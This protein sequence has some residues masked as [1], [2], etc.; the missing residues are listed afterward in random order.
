MSHATVADLGGT[1]KTEV[2]APKFRW[3]LRIVLPAFLILSLAGVF[4]G[5]LLGSLTPA[6]EVEV[7]PVVQRPSKAA[8]ATANPRA[9]GPVVVQAAGWIEPDPFPFNVTA[10]VSGTVREVLVLEGESVRAG[11]ILVRLVD[12]DAVLKHR[13]AEAELAAAQTSWDTN[14]EAQ[15]EYEVALA[16]EAE[17]SAT[18]GL[19]RAELAAAEA[20]LVEAKLNFQ[21][22]DALQDS[23]SSS[24]ANYTAAEAELGVRT[25]GVVGAGHRIAALAAQLERASAERHAAHQ[26]LQLRT[27]ERLRLELAR[28]MADEAKLAVDRLEIRSPI[29]GVVMTRLVE[30]GSRLM[31]ESNSMGGAMVAQLYDPKQMQVRVDVPLADAAKVG[32]GQ[33][34]EV[35]VEILSDRVFRGTVSR[36]TNFADIQ[37]NTLQVKVALE[38]PAPELKPEMLARVRFHGQ[39]SPGLADARSG[40]L[41]AFAPSDAIRDG[42]AWVVA[43]YDGEHGVATARTVTTSG[44]ASDGWQEITEGL[45]PGDLVIL[46]RNAEL[47]EGA[48]VRARNFEGGGS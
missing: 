22:Q 43:D 41:A 30:P 27:E 12:E 16:T 5:S 3:G 4:A 44:A 2:P 33:H 20:S 7:L 45:N 14:V 8:G 37:K 24:Y 38:D 31:L 21:R 1:Q 48:R 28:V 23:G 19:A 13:R 35:T 6:V 40:R 11:D 29:T 17:T 47:T 10:L 26:N 39:N 32:F 46:S 18:L 9:T 36:V 15:R 42:K 34:A 25:A